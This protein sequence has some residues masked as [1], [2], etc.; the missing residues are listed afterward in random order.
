MTGTIRVLIADDHPLMRRGLRTL[1]ATESDIE[2]VGEAEDGA[3]AVAK[4]AALKPDILVLDMVMPQMDGLQTIK[5]VRAEH[6][7]VRIMV[8]SSF[9]DDERVFPAIEAGALGYLLKDTSPQALLQAIR[10]VY[11]G[12]S[13]LHPTIARKL[14]RELR[15]TASPEHSEHTLTD[16]EIEV[17]RLVSHGLSNREIAKILV[18]SDRTVAAHVR[19]I[20]SK[21][22]L[23]NRTQAVLYALREGLVEL[24]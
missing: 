12:E 15:H 2:L 4:T 19:H 6:P 22:D 14:I 7:D 1:I 13:S 3:E 16:R 9:G 10:D 8:L 24:E 23:A 21:L 20:L 5:A 11:R 17:L 18:I